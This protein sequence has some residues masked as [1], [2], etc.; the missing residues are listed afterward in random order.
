MTSAM[1]EQAKAWQHSFLLQNLELLGT[2][3]SKVTDRAQGL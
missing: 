1:Y 3:I 2:G